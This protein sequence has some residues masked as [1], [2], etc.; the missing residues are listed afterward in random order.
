MSSESALYIDEEITGYSITPRDVSGNSIYVRIRE[1]TSWNSSAYKKFFHKP[2]KNVDW[3]LDGISYKKGGQTKVKKINL[4]NKFKTD[5]L[6]Y[7]ETYYPSQPK[8][9]ELLVLGF[10]TQSDKKTYVG[11]SDLSLED[12]QI[13]KEDVNGAKEFQKYIHKPS[14]TANGYKNLV[15]DCSSKCTFESFE[16]TEYTKDNL[17][18]VSVYFHK[19]DGSNKVPLLIEIKPKTGKQFGDKGIT[20]SNKDGSSEFDCVYTNDTCEG[21]ISGTVTT[22]GAIGTGVVLLYYSDTIADKNGPVPVSW[23]GASVSQGVVPCDTPFLP[24]LLTPNTKDVQKGTSIGPWIVYRDSLFYKNTDIKLDETSFQSIYNNRFNSIDVYY[25]DKNEPLLVEFVNDSDSRY[26]VRKDIKGNKWEEERQPIYVSDGNLSVQLQ[27]ISNPLFTNIGLQLE[28]KNEYDTTV[29][30]KGTSHK[31]SISVIKQSDGPPDFKAKGY[32]CYEHKLFEYYK[33]LDTNR[34]VPK[35]VIEPAI[36]TI[37]IRLIGPDDRMPW[38]LTYTNPD[39][40]TSTKND[41]LFVY[42]GK[43]NNVISGVN[44]I[45][46]SDNLPLLFCY[47]D[48]FYSPR[49][50]DQYFGLWLDERVTGNTNEGGVATPQSRLKDALDR[51]FEIANEIDLSQINSYGI[52]CCKNH[53]YY[54]KKG[55]FNTKRVNVTK[56]KNGTHTMYVHRTVH[57]NNIGKISQTNSEYIFNQHTKKLHS[58]EKIDE[59]V[60]IYSDSYIRNQPVLI[61]LNKRGEGPVANSDNTNQSLTYGYYYQDNKTTKGNAFTQYF[62]KHIKGGCKIMGKLM[63]QAENVGASDVCIS[64]LSQAL[65]ETWSELTS[66]KM[67]PQPSYDLEEDTSDCKGPFE[68]KEKESSGMCKEVPGLDKRKEEDYDS[69]SEED[70]EEKKDEITDL[71]QLDRDEGILN[72][73]LGE[74]LIETPSG[75]DRPEGQDSDSSEEDTFD[76]EIIPTV[77]SRD[78]GPKTVITTS[79]TFVASLPGMTEATKPVNSRTEAPGPAVTKSEAPR[80]PDST[81]SAPESL[82][83]SDLRTPAQ[84]PSLASSQDP[85]SVSHISTQSRETSQEVP[86]AKDTHMPE[87]GIQGQPSLPDQIQP[88]HQKHKS[89]ETNVRNPEIDRSQQNTVS[90]TLIT[91]NQTTSSHTPLQENRE[92]S[93]TPSLKQEF[94]G[95]KLV[96]LFIEKQTSYTF[97]EFY[98]FLK[99]LG[100]FNIEDVLNTKDYVTVKPK[101]DAIWNRFKSGPYS[102]SL[103]LLF[104]FNIKLNYKVHNNKQG[105][106]LMLPMTVLILQRELLQGLLLELLWLLEEP[107]LES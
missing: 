61:L 37:K 97:K 18:N 92:P 101:E 50:K 26:F 17:E 42:F 99:S 2:T 38:P 45:D 52:P 25:N 89:S 31:S 103:K 13:Q 95:Q 90:K 51:N 5:P 59:V 44:N 36:G 56:Y 9:N 4:E 91:H 68:D 23:T 87:G 55:G 82:P 19:S 11:R 21:A 100:N 63:G 72:V 16:P 39:Y 29:T 58:E 24:V 94:T 74:E 85:S 47:N 12:D 79:P 35:L 65:R 75:I 105:F 66:K 49:S 69:Y 1:D 80:F 15:L 76:V 96:V 46:D 6:K 43:S 104:V 33:R 30:I 22:I 54:N 34:S 53:P 77:E 107:L 28:K 93:G 88:D 83:T 40:S 27:T 84:V 86:K 60:V 98:T 71:N 106:N 3:D 10:V 20:K 7:F 70:E 14:S 57:K 8:S 67:D 78:V 81:I 64:E 32:F 62:F 73:L 41:S 48:K 102:A